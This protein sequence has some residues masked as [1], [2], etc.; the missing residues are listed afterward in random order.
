MQRSHLQSV[1]DLENLLTAT[2]GKLALSLTD[3]LQT[4]LGITGNKPLS[5]DVCPY[6][7]SPPPI[8][9]AFAELT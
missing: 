3:S 7:P 8:R 5:C 1:I 6:R 4:L 9:L 2:M